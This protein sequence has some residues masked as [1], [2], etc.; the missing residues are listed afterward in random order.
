MRE[1]G[2][3]GDALHAGLAPAIVD[4]KVDRLILI[5]DEFRPLETALGGGIHIDRATNADEA[6]AL[7]LGMIAPGD[8]ILVKASNSVGLAALVERVAGEQPCFT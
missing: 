3:H 8:V 6:T 4:A 5:G 2:T 7:L 1:V